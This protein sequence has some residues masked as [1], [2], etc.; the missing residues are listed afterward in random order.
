MTPDY[1]IDELAAELAEFAEPVREAKRSPLEERVLAGFE[2]IQRWVTEHGRAPQHGEGLDIFERLYA[3]RLERIRDQPELRTLVEATDHQSLLTGGADHPNN[4][5]TMSEDELASELEGIGDLASDI[6]TLQH[7][8]SR[9]EIEAAEEIASRRPCRDFEI[10]RPI[11][12]RVRAD[13]RNGVRQARAF[14][15][16]VGNNTDARI[17]TGDFYIV[18][19]QMA[20]VAEMGERYKTPEGAQQARLRVIYDNGTESDLLIRSLQTALYKDVAGR[21]ITEPNDGPLFT[22]KLDAN[23]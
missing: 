1:D 23:Q 12:E 16:D 3:V 11:F 18:G 19:G 17:R 13:L 14:N 22:G 9:K 6:T 15:K 21:R 4:P 7:V 5:A 2:E 8:R 10:F 20:Y